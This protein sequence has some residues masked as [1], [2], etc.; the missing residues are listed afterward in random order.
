MFYRSLQLTRI[1]TNG[2][3]EITAT[4]EAA[5]PITKVPMKEETT[6]TQILIDTDQIVGRTE[7]MMMTMTGEMVQGE[8]IRLTHL[9][10]NKRTPGIPI[11]LHW[12]K[13]R[14]WSM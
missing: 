13:L 8:T 5:S 3:T 2:P 11:L 6:D 9:I 1:G 10:K 14:A 12:I 4:G 7:E